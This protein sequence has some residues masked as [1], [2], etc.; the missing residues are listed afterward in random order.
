MA[1]CAQRT[2]LRG[3]SR[4]RIGGKSA[5]IRGA[6]RQAEIKPLVEDFKL[7][8]DARLGEV[9]Q[10]SGLA[11]AIRYALSHWEGLTRF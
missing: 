5:D 7:W 10:K 3:W 2:R 9:S 4:I 6:V 1:T 11:K 8:L